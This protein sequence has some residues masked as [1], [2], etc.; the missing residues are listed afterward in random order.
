MKTNQQN[1]A[2]RD[3]G[4]T[5][6]LSSDFPYVQFFGN[7]QLGF[8]WNGPLLALALYA[9][10]GIDDSR[11]DYVASIKEA[12]DFACRLRIPAGV[13]GKFISKATAS[14]DF[15]APSARPK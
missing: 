15:P 7:W 6:P 1:N 2:A 12:V 8:F 9:K 3:E 11:T 5:L 14:R 10:R 4:R 13:F